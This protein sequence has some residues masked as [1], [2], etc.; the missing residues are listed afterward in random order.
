MI[1]K[2]MGLMDVLTGIMILLFHYA[3][4]DTRL[5]AS[6]IL[7]LGVKAFMFKGDFA[8]FLD[9]AVAVYMILMIFLPITL[10]SYIVA[11]YLF[12]KGFSSFFS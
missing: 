4:I 3:L 10:L 8:S 2:F 7:Y 6:F 12:Q 11:I 5:L 1:L 9:A